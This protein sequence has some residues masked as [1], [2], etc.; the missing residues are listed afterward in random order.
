MTIE[1]EI[2]EEQK[3]SPVAGLASVSRVNR[4]LRL[5]TNRKGSVVSVVRELYLRNDVPC[6]SSL[7]SSSCDLNRGKE[8]V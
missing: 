4:Q 6:R 2:C 7:C 5:K 8:M 1:E 3:T